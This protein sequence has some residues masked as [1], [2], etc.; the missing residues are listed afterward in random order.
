[1]LVSDQNQ[2]RHVA[3][4][5]ALPS[6][7]R[8]RQARTPSSDGRQH[9][10]SERQQDARI[11]ICSH[12]EHRVRAR[13]RRTRILNWRHAR[14][15]DAHG[16]RRELRHHKGHA[17]VSVYQLS[18]RWPKFR[19]FGVDAEHCGYTSLAD[20]CET[21]LASTNRSRN[22]FVRFGNEPTLCSKNS[23]TANVVKAP[24]IFL[25]GCSM[26]QSTI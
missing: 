15:A 16:L 6:H 23:N 9:T 10:T 8:H 25:C 22:R 11:A 26:L 12:Q 4:A 1:M 21:S 20:K 18:K 17:G 13:S 19:R 24:R 7:P 3:A 2:A 14:Q 5:D